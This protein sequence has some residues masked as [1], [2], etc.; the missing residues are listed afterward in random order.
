MGG[1]G[2]ERSRVRDR[3]RCGVNRE[4]GSRRG[5]GDDTARGRGAGG[6]ETGRKEI[7]ER[8]EKEKNGKE[9][10]ER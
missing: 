6:R 5:Q 9:T 7:T 2:R 3:E 8:V 4:G 10:K 1:G